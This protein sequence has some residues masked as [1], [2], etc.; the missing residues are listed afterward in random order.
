MNIAI[1]SP[2]TDQFDLCGAFK[3]RNL[4]KLICDPDIIKKDEDRYTE[5]NAKINASVDTAVIMDL[6]I[7]TKND[8]IEFVYQLRLVP[9][10]FLRTI[11]II[12]AECL[13]GR[14]ILFPRMRRA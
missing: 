1:H 14:Q 8:L 4:S 6:Q 3:I 12:L 13:P 7:L 9:E 2:C 5:A 10:F 11:I